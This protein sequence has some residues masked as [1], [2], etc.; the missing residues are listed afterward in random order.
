MLDELYSHEDASLPPRYNNDDDDVGRT[1][2]IPDPNNRFSLESLTYWLRL[3]DWYSDDLMPNV[4]L[5]DSIDG[6]VRMLNESMTD[7]DLTTVSRRMSADN[8]R[9]RR[10]LTEQWTKI[11][12]RIAAVNAMGSMTSN[13]KSSPQQQR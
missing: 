8:D 11:L 6:L 9:S 4:I 13:N 2:R 7:R 1:P 5:Y 3:C 12:E 10:R